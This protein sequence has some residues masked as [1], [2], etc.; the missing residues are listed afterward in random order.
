MVAI[1]FVIAGSIISFYLSDNI[2]RLLVAF[3]L[4][5]AVSLMLNKKR[6]E[7]KEKCIKNK[8]IG[9]HHNHKFADNGT[10]T[11]KNGKTYM[12]CR[13][14]GMKKRMFGYALGGLFQGSSGFGIGE[15]GILSMALTNIP[16]R[17]AIGTSHMIVASTAI[18]AS[19]LHV[20]QSVNSDL[21]ILWNIFIATVPAVLI[22]GQIAPYISS[23]LKI[24]FLE[25]FIAFLFIIIS[26]SLVW[27]SVF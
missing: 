7:S 3:S 22:G 17:V 25:Y 2:L 11:D 6:R 8:T 19:I 16:I 24:S 21:V 26:L 13:F 1:P 4:I 18:I 14:C 10:L 12:Y 9:K 5:I 15:L 27:I 23:K 20:T